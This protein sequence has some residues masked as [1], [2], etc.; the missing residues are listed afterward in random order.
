MRP[1]LLPV[2]ALL[3]ACGPDD[4]YT[5]ASGLHS[6]DYLPPVDS[7]LQYGP[8]VAPADGPFLMIEVGP[9]SWELR[10]G[11]SW[12]DAPSTSSLPYDD[13]DGLLLEGVRVLPG[14]LS[15]GAEQDG[16]TVLTIGDEEVYYG[17]FSMA[18]RCE[19]PAGDYAGEWIFAPGLGPIQLVI[20]G[21]SWELVYYL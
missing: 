17:T 21:V 13:S 2:L 5:A 11:E 20:D 6:G 18:A 14:E 4:P 3:A 1:A 9:D 10:Q 7:W 16:V 19:V 12:N 8:K 15:E